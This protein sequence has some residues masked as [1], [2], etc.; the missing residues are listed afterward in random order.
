MNPP[1]EGPPPD[2]QHAVRHSRPRVPLD[3]STE[4]GG[5]VTERGAK[6]AWIVLAAASMALSEGKDADGARASRAESEPRQQE[7]DD[8]S[9]PVWEP[10]QDASG[11]FRPQPCSGDPDAG[12]TRRRL[13]AD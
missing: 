2:D 11:G 3:R 12:A 7:A 5:H 6:A 4:A 13:T 9:D 10:R 8:A 1:F